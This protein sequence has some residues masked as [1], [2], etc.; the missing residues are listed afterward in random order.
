M[1]EIV[2][3][4]LMKADLAK[5]GEIAFEAVEK[6]GMVPWAVRTPSSVTRLS[7]SKNG[8]GRST[9][10][11]ITKNGTGTSIDHYGPIIG[12]DW[13]TTTRNK[14]HKKYEKRRC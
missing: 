7:L 1:E 9:D 13:I 4:A 6:D 11:R 2:K 12:V 5:E 8:S 14:R 3:K 10:A